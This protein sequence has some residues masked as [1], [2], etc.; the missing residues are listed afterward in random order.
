MYKTHAMEEKM[1]HYVTLVD[2]VAKIAAKQPEISR[3]T[4]ELLAAIAR[5]LIGSNDGKGP[6]AACVDLFVR[7]AVAS[8]MGDL[9][10]AT[11]LLAEFGR[12]K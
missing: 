2:S 5:P 12:S 3:Q 6:V 1:R 4:V 9:A 10:F 11:N 7:F 8:E